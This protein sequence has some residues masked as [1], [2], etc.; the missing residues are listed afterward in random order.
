MRVD[1]I[2]VVP[3]AKD[4]KN[5]SFTKDGMDGRKIILRDSIYRRW[6]STPVNDDTYGQLLA[7]Y[8]SYL[9]SNVCDDKMVRTDIIAVL[10]KG[11][12]ERFNKWLRIGIYGD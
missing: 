4:V 11:L 9:Q 7:E 6:A 12:I 10:Y 3:Q 5:V 2:G 8:G 1:K